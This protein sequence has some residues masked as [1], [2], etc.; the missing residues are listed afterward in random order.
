MQLGN[1]IEKIYRRCI[2]S[3]SNVNLKIINIVPNS[4]FYPP[5][6]QCEIYNKLI[7]H[8]DFC[9]FFENFLFTFYPVQ[10][11]DINVFFDNERNINYILLEILEYP[12]RNFGINGKKVY[13]L[14]GSLYFIRWHFC[15]FIEKYFPQ[16]SDVDSY[17]YLKCLCNLHTIK[18]K[19][20]IEKDGDIF[21]YPSL[22]PEM[23]QNI[24]RLMQ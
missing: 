8:N 15:K 14:G 2:I 12:Q 20:A 16:F 6:R 23:Y 22:H 4:I 24:K 19:K 1:E 21:M 17:R 5:D 11:D 3:Q 9:I 7:M 13:V 18:N 10:L